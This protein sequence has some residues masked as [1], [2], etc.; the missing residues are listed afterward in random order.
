MIRRSHRFVTVLIGIKIIKLKTI[1]SS[2]LPAAASRITTETSQKLNRPTF[3]RV[4]LFCCLYNLLSLAHIP[5]T[6]LNYMTVMGNKEIPWS[7]RDFFDSKNGLTLTMYTKV[8]VIVFLAYPLLSFTWALFFGTTQEAYTIYA[9]VG[10]WI[11]RHC[12]RYQPRQVNQTSEPCLHA[13]FYQTAPSSPLL[14][15]SSRSSTVSLVALS[16]SSYTKDCI[17]TPPRASLIQHHSSVCSPYVDPL[18]TAT[19][20]TFSFVPTLP[21]R[22]CLFA[23]HSIHST[24]GTVSSRT[25]DTSGATLVNPS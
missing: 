6:V 20:H 4:F 13:S 15:L 5:N 11:R 7:E 25:T 9:T 2:S 10:R 21:D 18:H 16:N 3:Y 22:S 17:K 1:F 24:T 8:E 19:R 14:P 23:R 12:L